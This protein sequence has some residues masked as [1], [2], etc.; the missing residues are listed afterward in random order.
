ML[1][2]SVSFGIGFLAFTVGERAADQLKTYGYKR[3]EI[4]AAVFNGVTL[5]LISVY[6][7]YEAYH[8]FADPPEVATTGML[9]IAVFGL[10]INIFVA[11]ILFR[12][13]GAK[14]NLNMHAAFLHGLGDLLGSIGAITAAL[15]IMNF[16]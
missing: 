6:I 5:V 4:L 11:W 14:E 1:S 2:D 10:L 12:G 16:G 15:L 9:T 7:F 3:F 13:G 8:R